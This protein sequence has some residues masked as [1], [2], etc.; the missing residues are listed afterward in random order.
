MPTTPT[1]ITGAAGDD[2]DL[3][4][5]PLQALAQFYRAF[6]GRDLALMRQSWLTTA[7]ASM[8]NPIGGIRRGW[9]EIEAGYARIFGGAAQVYVEFYDYSLHVAGEMFLAVGRE[10]G[11]FRRDGQALELHIRT[12]RLFVRAEDGWRQLHHHGSI[13]DPALLA[14]Y[15]QAVRPQ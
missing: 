7:E 6:N 13:D 5:L 4:S 9:A 1:P 10:R 3:G 15:Q 14:A 12:S 2:A 8:D 11:H